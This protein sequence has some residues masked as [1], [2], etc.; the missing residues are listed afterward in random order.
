MQIER[1]AIGDPCG[2]VVPTV[3]ISAANV[4]MGVEDI[5]HHMTAFRRQWIFMLCTRVRSW[6]LPANFVM[7]CGLCCVCGVRGVSRGCC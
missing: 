1:S 5:V 2:A 6:L 7:V 3:W 4:A